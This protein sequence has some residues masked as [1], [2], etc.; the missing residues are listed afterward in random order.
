MDKGYTTLS[1]PTE[2]Y[3]KV[4]KFIKEHPEYGYASVTEFFKDSLRKNLDE[5]GKRS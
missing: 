2:L 4:E 5:L 1:I 3:K